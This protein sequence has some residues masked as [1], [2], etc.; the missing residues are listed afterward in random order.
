MLSALKPILPILYIMVSDFSCDYDVI[1][2][3]NTERRIIQ[4]SKQHQSTEI[5]CIYFRKCFSR[6][7]ILEVLQ[8]LYMF[9]CIILFEM[10]AQ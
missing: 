9:Y 10:I 3:K 5:T 7:I 2:F 8:T 4:S 1:H 6:F